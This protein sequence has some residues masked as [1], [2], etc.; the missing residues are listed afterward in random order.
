LKTDRRNFFQGI[1]SHPYIGVAT[2]F[3]AYKL[4]LVALPFTRSC[5]RRHIPGITP[6]IGFLDNP[7]RNRAYG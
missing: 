1:L 7:T 4:L 3:I 5:P 6:G 2:V